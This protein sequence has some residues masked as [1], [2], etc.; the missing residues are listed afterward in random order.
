MNC[1]NFLFRNLILLP[2]SGKMGES[3]ELKNR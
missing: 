1:K 2:F 3:G